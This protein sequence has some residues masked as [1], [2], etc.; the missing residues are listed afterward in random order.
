MSTKNNA[1]ANEQGSHNF[2]YVAA[3]EI[4]IKMVIQLSSVHELYSKKI[5]ENSFKTNGLRTL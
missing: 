4:C 3:A 2:K 1:L 5:L